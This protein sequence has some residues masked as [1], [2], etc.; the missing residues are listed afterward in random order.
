MAKKKSTAPTPPAPNPGEAADPSATIPDGS[1]FEIPP[2]NYAGGLFDLAYRYCTESDDLLRRAFWFGAAAMMETRIAARENRARIKIQITPETIL[3]VSSTAKAI[4][5]GAADSFA[6][7]PG[8]RRT[9]RTRRPAP[10][11]KRAATTR[12]SKR[13]RKPV[14][15]AEPTPTPS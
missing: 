4:F 13:P 6:S 8:K 15:K 2:P 11:P 14:G 5:G 1:A 9:A 10:A 3:A 7:P 12:G